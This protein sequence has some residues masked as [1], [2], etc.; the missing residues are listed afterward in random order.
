M[1]QELDNKVFPLSKR[2]VGVNYPPIHPWCRSTTVAVIDGTTLEGLKRRARD[3][4][5]GKTYLVPADM[6]YE[7]WKRSVDEKKGAGTVDKSRKMLYNEKADK[8][9][10]EKYKS[11]FGDEMP[12]TFSGFQK[13]KYENKQIWD[14]YKARARTKNYL[15]EQLAYVYNG[16]KLFIPKHTKFDTIKTIAGSGTNTPIRIV[17]SLV[18]EY[19]GTPSEWKKRAGKITSG[20]YIFDVHWYERGE[21]QFDVKLKHRRESKK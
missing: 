2:Q 16:E 21:M 20:K 14:E 9:Q 19:G 11:I 8:L 7:E 5:T 6:S 18:K 10:Y 3:P 15:H 12:K 1:C 13:L 4:E 17:D